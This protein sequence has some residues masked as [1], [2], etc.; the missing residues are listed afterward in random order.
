[1]VE[2]INSSMASPANCPEAARPFYLMP[3]GQA[4]EAPHARGCRRT[5]VAG[6]RWPPLAQAESHML[7]L[8]RGTTIFSRPM[9]MMEQGFD[10]HDYLSPA[11]TLLTTDHDFE[12]CE[13]SLRT[14][15]GLET[16]Q[17]YISSSHP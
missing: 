15:N 14:E 7:D 17:C 13:D 3:T 11:S 1:M 5:R 9:K 6:E 2:R 10:C 16:A 12:G 8:L 4:W